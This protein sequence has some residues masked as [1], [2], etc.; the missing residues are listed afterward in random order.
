MFPPTRLRK[1]VPIFATQ[2]FLIELKHQAIGESR[3]PPRAPPGPVL[4]LRHA[5]RQLSRVTRQTR[6]EP[7]ILDA[8]LLAIP[9]SPHTLPKSRQ[10]GIF[11]TRILAITGSPPG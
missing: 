9:P 1:W 4:P 8:G 6:G 3:P 7:G 11:D 10:L 2:L 5:V